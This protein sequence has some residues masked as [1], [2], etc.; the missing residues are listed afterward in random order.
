MSWSVPHKKRNIFQ[1]SCPEETYWTL[2][3]QY[4]TVLLSKMLPALHPTT[5]TT[6]RPAEH[7]PHFRQFKFVFF[8]AF[9]FCLSTHPYPVLHCADT[10]KYL[11]AAIDLFSQWRWPFSGSNMRMTNVSSLRVSAQ[12]WKL[13]LHDRGDNTDP[14]SC[15]FRKHSNTFFLAQMVP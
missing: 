13:L 11:L 9:S 15:L 7:L 1:M 2:Q 4:V 8:L 12:T 10:H 3:I 6:T 14:E 5:L